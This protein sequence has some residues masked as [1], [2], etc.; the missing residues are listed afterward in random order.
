MHPFKDGNMTVALTNF[1][2]YEGSK[3][4]SNGQR[5]YPVLYMGSGKNYKISLINDEISKSVEDAKL[6]K[7][8][9]QRNPMVVPL[10]LGVP[11]KLAKSLPVRLVIHFSD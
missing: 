9:F 11:S 5:W 7:R 10:R 1:N 3:S 4:S 8:V 6:R 2:P